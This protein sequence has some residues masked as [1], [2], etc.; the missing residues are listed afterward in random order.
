VI[1]ATEALAQEVPV[2]CAC[3]ALEFPRSSLYRARQPRTDRRK[4]PRPSPPR[5]LSRAEKEAVHTVLNDERFQDSPPRQVYATLLDEGIY[6]CSIST[7]YRILHEH[8]QVHE[9]RDQR[10]H[11]A[12]TKPELLATASN[13]LWS[14]DITKLK[15][16]AKWVYFYLYVILDVFSRYVVGWLI[17]GHESA[18]LAEQLI[19]ESC[20]KQQIDP[21]QLTL[22]SDRGPS[23]TSKT[24]AQLLADLSIAKTHSRPY[25]ANDNP[26]SESQFKT[27]KYRPE[28]PDRFGGLA[29]ARAWARPFFNW[30]NNEHRHSSLGLMT[31][32]MVHYGQAAEVMAQRQAILKAAYETHPERFVKGLPIPPQLPEAAWINPPKKNGKPS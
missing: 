26:F 12:Y 29:D 18:A 6:H 8:D 27:M 25:T 10:Q 11:P 31:P 5:A 19:S 13:Q 16:P 20:H 32:A 7:M 17:A 1:Q 9:R 3:E 15:G 28:Y 4:Q 22:H 24:V 21:D 30:Y 23:M 14:W 2:S